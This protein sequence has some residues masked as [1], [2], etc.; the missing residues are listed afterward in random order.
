M[1]SISLALAS[2]F[3][4]LALCP[5]SAAVNPEQRSQNSRAMRQLKT[6]AAAA[7]RKLRRLQGEAPIECLVDDPRDRPEHCPEEG[8]SVEVRRQ[9]RTHKIAEPSYIPVY[10]GFSSPRP[11]VANVP[12]GRRKPTLKAA[13]FRPR[14]PEELTPES[15]PAPPPVYSRP[16]SEPA[17]A[18]AASAAERSQSRSIGETISAWWD[19]FSG[20]ARAA[21]VAAVTRETLGDFK[22][23]CARVVW[24]ALTRVTGTDPRRVLGGAAESAHHVI[25]AVRRGGSGLLAKMGLV[26]VNP[27]GPGGE[28]RPAEGMVIYWDAGVCGFH[29]QYGH[30]EIVTK[31]DAKNLKNSRATSDGTQFLRTDCLRKAVKDGRALVAMPMEP[32]RSRS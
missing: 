21:L 28:L 5:L 17:S 14:V 13:D 3:A 10:I 24:N 19:Y 6:E 27:L 11:L 31:V 8:E 32:R 25:A 4:A 23:K 29:P 7:K 18:P 12:P 22:G 30:T 16:A 15:V 1:T 2:I 9:F 20:G 26:E